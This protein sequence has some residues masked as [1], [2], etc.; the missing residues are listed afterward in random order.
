[1]VE[2]LVSAGRKSVWLFSIKENFNLEKSWLIYVNLMVSFA[3]ICV[4]TSI[5]FIHVYYTIIHVISYYFNYTIKPYIFI[6]PYL[7]LDACSQ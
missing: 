2:N 4:C 5:H 1:M 3:V 6:L 7:L